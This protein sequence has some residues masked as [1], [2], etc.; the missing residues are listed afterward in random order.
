MAFATFSPKDVNITWAAKAFGA[1][2]LVGLD[3]DSFITLSRNNQ[4]TTRTVG[5]K[6][7]S[8]ITR[9]ADRTGTVSISLMQTSPSNVWLGTVSNAMEVSDYSTFEIFIGDILVSDPSGSVLCW[10]KGA[11]LQSNPEVT[12]GGTDQNSRTWE[13]NCEELIYTAVPGSLGTA[14][15]ALASLGI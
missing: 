9:I 6:G 8:S 11:T 1:Y 12:L 2:N 15:S 10:A 5:A 14:A 3:Q 7:E 13:F 4:L